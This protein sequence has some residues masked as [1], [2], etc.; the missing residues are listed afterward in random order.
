MANVIEVD[1]ATFEERVVR[2]SRRGPVVVD[3]W[4]SWCRP[5]LV[6]GPLLERLVEERAG[7]ITLA[8]VD[9]DAN[10]ALAGR[11]GVQGIPAVKAF[12]DGEVA[13]EFVGAQPE[14]VVE[15]FLDA[16][17]PSEADELLDAAR[18]HEDPVS[19]YRQAL[20]LEP[21]HPGAAAAL[22]GILVEHGEAEEAARVLAAAPATDEIRRVRAELELRQAAEQPDEV[23]AAARAALAGD[24]RA[25]LEVAL[26]SLTDGGDREA[27]RAFMLDV[28]ARLGDEHPLTREFR[29]R[30]AAA[31][32]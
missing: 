14:Q 6:L 21:G 15:R 1:E 2:A 23:G 4:A 16:L 26:A 17:L 32:F 20:E 28:F 11:F 24:D 27:A 5:C 31:L 10:Q 12:V 30:L 19:L 3:F 25:A 29:P 13:A 9:V 22:A 18:S 8:K 7:R